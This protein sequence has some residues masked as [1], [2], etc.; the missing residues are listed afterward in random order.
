MAQ[1]QT[2]VRPACVA[3][4]S[5]PQRNCSH[6]PAPPHPLLQWDEGRACGKCVTAWCVDDL[7]PVKG[8]RVQVQITDLC[9]E[10]KEGQFWGG[11]LGGWLANGRL[12]G[13]V[14]R[15][16]RVLLPAALCPAHLLSPA[17]CRPSPT[18]PLPSLPPARPTRT[19]DV[20]FS[21]PVYREITGMWPHRLAI[22]WEWSDCSPQI[23]GDIIVTPKV[24]WV[25]VVGGCIGWVYWWVGA[26]RALAACRQ[27]AP[28]LAC[29]S[30]ASLRCYHSPLPPPPPALPQDG[31]N[32]QWQAFYFAN[33]R[34]PL[35]KV[36]LNGKELQREQFQVGG[37]V[38]AWRRL[39]F[40]VASCLRRRCRPALAVKMPPAHV[41]T[42]AVAPHPAS[43]LLALTVLDPQ[44]RAADPRHL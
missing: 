19:G 7:C 43:P 6:P 27:R 10:C 40:P 12:G 1:G 42:T 44:R 32:A 4:A 17:S 8:K 41:S 33:F 13:G 34:Y 20:D 36:L 16:L 22:Q 21:I 3:I 25:G 2:A 18:L 9:P 15:V 24:G 28:L 31:I 30:A 23:E 38:G 26:A 11:R 14:G 35:N 39:P 37:R 5:T 29:A